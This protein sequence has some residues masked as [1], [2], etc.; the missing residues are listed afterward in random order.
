VIVVPPPKRDKVAFMGIK[1]IVLVL[2]NEDLDSDA[3]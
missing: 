2:E 1:P 3:F